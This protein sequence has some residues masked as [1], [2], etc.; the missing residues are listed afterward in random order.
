VIVATVT[1]NPEQS[2]GID[3]AL[4]ALREQPFGVWLL[5]AV[6]LGLMAYGVFMVVRSKYQRM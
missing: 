3:G 6:A 1:N 2:T 5:G 4:K